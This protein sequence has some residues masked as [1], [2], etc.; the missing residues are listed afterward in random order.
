VKIALD[1]NVL[2]SAIGT[3]GL[4]SDVLQVVL[5]EHEL[6]VGELVFTEL[7]KNLAKKFR[8]PADLIEEFEAML[9]AQA[10]TASAAGIR[11]I[12]GIDSADARVLAEAV[13]GEAEAFVTGDGELLALGNRAP[14]PI[15]SPRQLWEL[16]R[17]GD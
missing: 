14:L 1:T 10:T 15:L 7:R 8:L 5:L 11:A 6:V 12:V 16:L 4:C 17:R 9:R 3:R 13:A 2:A